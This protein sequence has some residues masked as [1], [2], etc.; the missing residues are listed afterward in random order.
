MT[1][2][3][4]VLYHQIH[5]LT[6]ATDIGAQI[7]AIVLF[8]AHSLVAGL[9]V[10]F[11]PPVTAS[12]IILNTVDLAPCKHSALGHYLARYMTRAMEAV[13]LAGTLPMVLG[14]WYHLPWLIPIGLG[15]TLLGW[16]R[17]VL[18]PTR[19]GV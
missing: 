8:W 13:R 4:K 10:M 15:V 6:L 3:E 9:L 16:L 19:A 17:G 7:G 14:A 11:V 2:R 1:R 12:L 5:P 18:F